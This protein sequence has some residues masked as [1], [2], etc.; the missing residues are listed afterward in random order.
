LT[1]LDTVYFITTT[2]PEFTLP[3]VAGNGVECEPLHITVPV[4]IN[5]RARIASTLKRV[6]WRGS[7]IRCNANNFAKRG[8]QVLGQRPGFDVRP[9]AGTHKDIPCFV[10]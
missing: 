1:C 4:R 5:F 9:L 8:V 7:T 3:K 2:R 10:E 6:A